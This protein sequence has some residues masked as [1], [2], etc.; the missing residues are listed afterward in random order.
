[1]ARQYYR[2]C[3]QTRMPMITEHV[4]D[5]V[6]GA[7]GEISI[8]QAIYTNKP[9]GR[10][11]LLA[12]QQ[13]GPMT[14]RWFLQIVMTYEREHSYN[15]ALI[16]YERY[17]TFA[18]SMIQA[19]ATEAPSSLDESKIIFPCQANSKKTDHKSPKEHVYVL[20][21]LGLLFEP[22]LLPIHLF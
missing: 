10:E 16:R 1:M 3:I 19:F 14:L 21:Y 9:E 8:I 11:A 15:N 13:W 6:Q 17:I 22:L 4:G 18:E 7:D 5:K 2:R 12:L 20:E